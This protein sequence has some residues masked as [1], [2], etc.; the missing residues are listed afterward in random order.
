MSLINLQTDLKTLKYGQD[1]LY[2]A[3]SDQPYI[4]TSIPND[5]SS[6]KG[7]TDFLLRGG[8]NVARDTIKDLER[9]KKMFTD[10]KSLNGLFFTTKQ[11]LLSRTAVRTQTS[12]ILNEGVYDPLNTLAQVGVVAFGGHLNKQGLNPFANTGAYS[13]NNNLYYNVVKPNPNEPGESTTNNRLVQLL[14]LTSNQIS[15]TKKN[16]ITLNNG[17][18]IMTYIGGPGSEL[19]AGNT[20]IRYQREGDRTFLTKNP[21][22]FINGST[23]KSPFYFGANYCFV[24]SSKQIFNPYTTLGNPQGKSSPSQGVLVSS[25]N[26]QQNHSSPKIQDFRRIIRLNLEK[27]RS[28][29]SNLNNPEGINVQ[30]AINS[31]VLPDN[32]FSKVNTTTYISYNDDPGQ[33][34]DKSY[35][36][37]VKGV[38]NTARNGSNYN[39]YSIGFGI[40]RGS[41]STGLDIINS[42]PIYRSEEAS[43]NLGDYVQFRIAII[44]NDAPLFKTFIHFRAFLDS[45]SDSY[46]ADWNSFKYLGRGENF[47]NYQGF[48]RQISLSWTVAA[49]SK[50]ELIRMYKKLNYLASSLTPDYSP[51]GYM[52]G[53]LAQLTVG[54]YLYEQPGI[55]TSLTYDVP[56]ESPW[57]IASDIE[58]RPGEDGTVKQL[59][60]IIR[61]TGFNFIPIQKFRPSIQDLTFRNTGNTDATSDDTGF[62]NT[63]GP[64]HYVSLANSSGNNYEKYNTNPLNP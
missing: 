36:N 5:I 62:V 55:I 63:Y 30:A 10:P 39:N 24:Y 11:E 40:N 12:G 8:T 22:D 18:N 29:I 1:R 47:Y 15:G 42:V 56:E 43:S 45:M 7:T 21:G 59:P 35:A 20:N 3:S 4:K 57:E 64:Q 44:D 31:G 51:S 50:E 46:N 58:G 17:I 54:G 28:I 27:N 61:V 34:Q 41:F 2:G 60:H 38:Q 37:Y 49:Q 14:G 19:G 48:S 32:T 6:Y 16:G 53:N 33:R 13:N 52:R 26:T 25:Q 23:V 9:I